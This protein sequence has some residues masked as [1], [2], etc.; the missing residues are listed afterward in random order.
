MPIVYA[1][2]GDGYVSNSNANWATARDATTGSGYNST[3]NAASS[4]LKVA[5]AAARGGGYTY[6]IMRVFMYF[7]FR[8]VVDIPESATLNIYGYTNNSADYFVVKS[9]DAIGSLGTSVFDAIY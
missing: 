6:S 4:T 7:D 1:D 3:L 2:T 5:V 8:T 9:T